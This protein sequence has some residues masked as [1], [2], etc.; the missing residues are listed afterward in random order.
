MFVKVTKERIKLQQRVKVFKGFV[1]W[2]N[3]IPNY[4]KE[5]DD[6]IY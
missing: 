2:L 1:Y 6:H 5:S 3:K 4:A